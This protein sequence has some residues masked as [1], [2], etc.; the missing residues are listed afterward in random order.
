VEYGKKVNAVVFAFRN[1][2]PLPLP[3]SKVPPV[4]FV[5]WR[6][7]F[8]SLYFDCLNS[9]FGSSSV[10]LR[11]TRIIL[12]NEQGEPFH[13]SVEIVY[14]PKNIVCF[15]ICVLDPKSG[16]CQFL[17]TSLMPESGKESFS[18]G[19]VYAGCVP[20]WAP[21]IVFGLLW[22]ST[23][24]WCALLFLRGL[25]LPWCPSWL[26]TSAVSLPPPLRVYLPA[27]RCPSFTAIVLV[28]FCLRVQ[29][30]C[31]LTGSLRVELVLRSSILLDSNRGLRC[32]WVLVEQ[33]RVL[34][35]PREFRLCSALGLICK[36]DV[37][38]VRVSFESP[39]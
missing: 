3:L 30:L 12:W 19:R 26:C 32:N 36:W 27:L 6:D 18:T 11:V 37:L 7:S 20:P 39:T 28:R 33:E 17:L 23:S 14:F 8:E 25:V 31:R 4:R 10:E 2:V 16:P 21:S 29:C 5:L 38:Q 9:Y 13:D 15:C 22:S 24:L 1:T 34:W 35:V